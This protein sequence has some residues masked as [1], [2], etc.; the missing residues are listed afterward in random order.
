MEYMD[1]GTLEIIKEKLNENQDKLNLV[2][3][4]Y[5][6]LQVLKGLTYLNKEL[7]IIHRD[8]K[9]ANILVNKAGDV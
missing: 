9:P 8:I 6:I 1:G 2:P 4:L 3:L 5:I 7:K